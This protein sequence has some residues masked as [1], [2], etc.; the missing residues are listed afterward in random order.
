MISED[1][2]PFN[3]TTYLAS[4]IEVSSLNLWRTSALQK[5]SEAASDGLLSILVG[6]IKVL[7]TP[8]C[9]AALEMTAPLTKCKAGDEVIMPSNTFVS[10]ARAFVLRGATPVLS[11]VILNY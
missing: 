5:L 3:S 7:L 4:E 9:K 10:T 2:I 11:T 1:I 6:G 8:S